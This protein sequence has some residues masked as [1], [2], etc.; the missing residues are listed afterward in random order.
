MYCVFQM[1]CR[2][3]STIV[4]LYNQTLNQIE[5][6]QVIEVMSIDIVIHSEVAKVL[7]GIIN[8]RWMKGQ[9]I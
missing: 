5:E 7:V 3:R 4:E 8:I 9:Q 6:E 1:I 2:C